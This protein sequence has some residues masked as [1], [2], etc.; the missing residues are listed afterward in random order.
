MAAKFLHE[1]K[2]DLIQPPRKAVSENQLLYCCRFLYAHEVMEGNILLTTTLVTILPL[3][4]SD[5]SARRV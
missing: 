4:H 5:H 1:N 3:Y 2:N